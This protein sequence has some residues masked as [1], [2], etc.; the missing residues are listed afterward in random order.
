M[1]GG[2]LSYHIARSKQS[3]YT[4]TSII[5]EAFAR[6]KRFV[7]VFPFVFPFF[8]WKGDFFFS[9]K[10]GKRPSSFFFT[11][12]QSLHFSRPRSNVRLRHEAL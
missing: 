11:F 5:D 4:L 8:V 9:P 1:C 10:K 12:C 6:I 2:G 7:S 3:S